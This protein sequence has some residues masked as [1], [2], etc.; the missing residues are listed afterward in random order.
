[1]DH[2]IALFDHQREAIDALQI[3]TR[4]LVNMWCGTGKTR[5]LTVDIVEC[6]PQLSIIIFP[7]LALINQ[8]NKD[9]LI[10]D[11]FKT[12]LS[13]YKKLS[14][15]S[16][17]DHGK[18]T[19]DTTVIESFLKRDCCKIVVVTYQSLELLS[20]IIIN[21]DITINKL[22]FDEAHHITESN[23]YTL[24]FGNNATFLDQSEQTIFYTATPVNRKGVT[25]Y[26]C[27]DENKSDCGPIAFQYLYYQA[28]EDDRCKELET[29][30]TL[31][32]APTDGISKF[33][34][35]FEIIIRTCLST[36]DREYWNILT[37]HGFV[38]DND[39]TDRSVKEFASPENIKLFKRRFA[40]IQLDEFPETV[41]QFDVDH[42]EFYG[43]GSKTH[44]RTRICD[45]F[46][47]AIPGR[48]FILSSCRTMGE[49]VDTKWA[50]MVVP[51]TPSQS[52]VRESQRIGRIT[53]MPEADMP[54]GIVLIPCMI[55]VTGLTG[56]NSEKN[57]ELIRD[58]IN[59]SDDFRTTLNVIGA[60]KYQHDPELYEKCLRYPSMYHPDEIK[61]NLNKR[62][63][64]LGTVM[65]NTPTDVIAELYDGEIK[66]DTIEDIA[67]EIG[68]VIEVHTQDY[69]NAITQYGD[70]DTDDEPLRV[71]HDE[72]GKYRV[73]TPMK[74]GGKV[75]KLKPA[76]KRKPIVTMH[77]HPDITMLL[78][79]DFNIADL[80][81]QVF[82]AVLDICVTDNTGVG[83]WHAKLEELKEYIIE[84]GKLPHWKNDKL[85]SWATTQKVNYKKPK[86]IMKDQGIRKAWEEFTNDY[87]L[88][89]RSDTEKWYAYLEELKEYI[90]ENDKLPLASKAGLGSWT[91]NQ[92][93]NYKSQ[94]YMTI[95]IRNTWEEFTTEY[96]LLFRSDTE[97]W[98][99]NL[100][101]L[102]E[103]II[104][105]GK[106]PILNSKGLGSWATTQKKN[107]KSQKQIMSDPD[108]R[109]AWEEFTNEYPI[110]FR[111][112]TEKWYAKLEELK[113]Y[114]IE[115]GKLPTRKAGLGQWTNMQKGNYKSQKDIMK[116]PDIRNAWNNFTLEY[117]LLFRSDTEKW[118]AYL[119]ELREYIIENGKLPPARK[120]GLGKWTSHQ[121]TN[122]KS[123]KKS[124]KDPDI[125]KAWEEFTTEY[126]QLFVKNLTWGQLFDALDE[127]ITE[128]GQRP[129]ARPGK[130]QAMGNWMRT[131]QAN[132][133][134]DTLDEDQTE[135]WD[136][137]LER[138]S[139]ALMSNV[140]KWRQNFDALKLSDCVKRPKPFRNFINE[141]L[142]NRKSLKGMMSDDERR[143]EWDEFVLSK[144]MWFPR[145]KP[146]QVEPEQEQKEQ[147]K[148][149]KEKKEQ[150][151]LPIISKLHKKYI[152]MNSDKLHNHF[153]ENEQDWHDYH[154][155][156]EAHESVYAVKEVP[157]LIVRNWL[158]C[159]P[160]KRVRTVADLGCGKALAYQ[161]F[162]DNKRYKF[163]NFDHVSIGEY[164]I[165]R[166]IMNTELDDHSVNTVIM[167]MSMWGSK[168]AGHITEA[169]RILEDGG[170]MIVIEPRKRW[171]NDDG[172]N[173]L[174]KL[175]EEVGMTVI[176]EYGEKIMTIKCIKC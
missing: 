87:P 93:T 136:D 106:L 133:D 120:A 142:R 31:Y 71:F 54:S 112:D 98:Y 148:E 131:Q 127:Y 8:F 123:Q 119:E 111:S 175:L 49:G 36:P 89:F 33:Q 22:I 105:N 70:T 141:Q 34:S 13:G 48:I 173:R 108:I 20:G 92:K 79:V 160:G 110:L 169:C 11:T 24:L 122:Y 84:N 58:Q 168:C 134:N 72:N 102:K 50:N 164:V 73:I 128:N 69:D 78:S 90:I 68:Y 61:D 118:Y 16:S 35:V 64:K 162:K 17:M 135:K 109:N 56:D 137:L 100:E 15:C 76:K 43:V 75:K 27:D 121:K 30:V 44:N 174:T 103:Y 97:K 170:R 167:S 25:M 163:H 46:D 1:M 51:I 129:S 116:D 155:I 130:D 47:N 151:V 85:G 83:K 91:D 172:S 124:M 4:C 159:I 37:F 3:H 82:S 166:N 28:V 6:E 32:T 138:H 14:V 114:I 80:E 146:I 126:L 12:A 52:I 57:D 150:C 152:T 165:A 139:D 145:N 26:D 38:E 117:P 99:A 113:E 149:K 67:D 81:K 143:D 66:A 132:Y 40:E 88:L 5:T 74:K 154:A 10:N 101:E 53:R 157:H 104:E 158:A 86:N 39:A 140:K 55:D 176:S 21:N 63:Y 95:D 125:R 62:G 96:P 171:V 144:P 2:G 147:K 7:S 29:R 107:Y 9:Y 94:K 77:T 45:D 60:F 19:T 65:H 59:I 41:M 153:H 18:Y 23:I 156:M 42:V 115:N 161:H